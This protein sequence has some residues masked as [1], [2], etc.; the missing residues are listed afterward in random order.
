MSL[1][2]N[3]EVVRRLFEEVWN[4]GEIDVLDEIMAVELIDHRNDGSS[5]PSN[6]QEQADIFRERLAGFR[7][8]CV[9]CDETIAEAD[10]I[11][12][13]WTARALNGE[14]GEE[15]KKL[16]ICIYRIEMGRITEIWTCY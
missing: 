4:Q 5:V 10:K 16:H 8:I 13:R 7:D 1:S 12:L 3:K 14:T 2:A 6:R 11:A 15:L 9:T